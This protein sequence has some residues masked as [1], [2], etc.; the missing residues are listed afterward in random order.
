[1]YI[2]TCTKWHDI[3]Q[4]KNIV[5]F[6]IK[7]TISSITTYYRIKLA[8]TYSISPIKWHAFNNNNIVCCLYGHLVNDTSINTNEK[9]FN[10]IFVSYFIVFSNGIK[11]MDD[12]IY[13]Q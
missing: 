13:G 2:Y 6:C 1:M 12:C 7:C 3:Q 9:G 5:L 4:G 10:N 11:K 8:Y